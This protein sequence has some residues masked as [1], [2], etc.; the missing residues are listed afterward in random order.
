MKRANP[1]NVPCVE[2][3]FTTT[4][5]AAFE[6]LHRKKELIPTTKHVVLSCYQA[7]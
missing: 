1:T 6:E 2:P 4:A 3:K 7:D 5:P